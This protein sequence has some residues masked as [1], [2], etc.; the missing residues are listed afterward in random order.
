MKGGEK[1]EVVVV[2]RE[3]WNLKMGEAMRSGDRIDGL[4][5]ELSC[6][7]TGNSSAQRASENGNLPKK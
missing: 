2:L 3:D 1:Q 4:Q 5:K 6:A 7:G